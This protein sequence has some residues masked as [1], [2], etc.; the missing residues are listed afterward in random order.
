MVKTNSETLSDYILR[1]ERV[2]ERLEG[3]LDA[4]AIRL[5]KQIPNNW[6]YKNF[7]VEGNYRGKSSFKRSVLPLDKLSNILKNL[8]SEGI[9]EQI[10]TFYGRDSK[11]IVKHYDKLKEIWRNNIIIE[12]NYNKSDPE[13]IGPTFKV[14]GIS[15]R[16]ILNKKVLKKA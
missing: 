6:N 15:Q 9:Y 16:D 4:I 13:F 14:A 7:D 2:D 8:V 10:P 5:Y 3:Q 12:V 11:K 1:K